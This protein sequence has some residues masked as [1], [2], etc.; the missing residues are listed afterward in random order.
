MTMIAKFW[1]KASQIFG[2]VNLD[3]TAGFTMT[4]TFGGWVLSEC[5]K[6]RSAW[7][8]RAGKRGTKDWLNLFYQLYKCDLEAN[9]HF[10]CLRSRHSLHDVNFIGSF[11]DCRL[12][13]QYLMWLINLERLDSLAIRMQLKI[14]KRFFCQR[15]GWWK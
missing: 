13:G 7:A 2:L 15:L 14:F 10:L 4:K 12:F 11:L 6:E 9:L 1:E 3:Y 5:T 8:F